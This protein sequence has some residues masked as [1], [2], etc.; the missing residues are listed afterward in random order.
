MTNVSVATVVISP[1]AT[2]GNARRAVDEAAVDEADEQ[3]E[4]ADADRDRPLQVHRDGVHHRLAQAGDD[5]D[6]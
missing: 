3:D 2:G 1:G 5:E 6:Q 4:E